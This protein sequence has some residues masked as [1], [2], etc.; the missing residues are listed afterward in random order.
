MFVRIFGTINIAYSGNVYKPGLADLSTREMA[1]LFGNTSG[2]SRREPRSL[3]EFRAGKMKLNGTTVSADTRK[4]LV[5]VK[6]EDGLLHFCWKDRKSGE[7]VDVSSPSFN[8]DAINMSMCVDLTLAGLY[9][10]PRGR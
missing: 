2:N 3:L 9:H 5:Y 1:A 4:G 6:M 8:T 10:I 7:V